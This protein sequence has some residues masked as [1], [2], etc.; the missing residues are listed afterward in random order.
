[1]K[2]K[3]VSVYTESLI[4]RFMIEASID[5]E[6]ASKCVGIYADKMMVY[7]FGYKRQYKFWT[8]VLNEV[9]KTK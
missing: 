8:E 7:A 9:K 5:R 6:S 1:L 4:S 2:D 3:S